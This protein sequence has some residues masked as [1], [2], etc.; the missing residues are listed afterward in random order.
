MTETVTAA[1]TTHTPTQPQL[2]FGGAAERS[3][4]EVPP[5]FALQPPLGP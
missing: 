3:V 1:R 5:L 4:P 2:T